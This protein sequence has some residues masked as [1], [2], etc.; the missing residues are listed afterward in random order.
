MSEAVVLVVA[1]SDAAKATIALIAIFGVLFPA[2]VTGMIVYAI[3]QA[4]GEKTENDE[5]RVNPRL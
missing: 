5:R 3:V 2:L 4:R 1:L